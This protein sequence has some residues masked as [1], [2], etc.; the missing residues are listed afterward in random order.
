MYGSE[1][2]SEIGKFCQLCYDL[3]SEYQSKSNMGQQ[4]SSH[5]ASSVSN[6]F[7]LTYDEQD[8]LSKF[9]L[10]VHSTNEEAHAKLELDYYLEEPVL[11]RIS[12]FDV[13]SWWKTNGKPK[14]R[15]SL[16]F[17]QVTV[18]HPK[19]V[20]PTKTMQNPNHESSRGPAS[21]RKRVVAPPGKEEKVD[22]KFVYISPMPLDAP[23]CYSGAGLLKNKDMESKERGPCVGTKGFRHL[24]QELVQVSKGM[25]E[26]SG[27]SNNNEMGNGLS[28]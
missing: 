6:L 4:T 18:T 26:L 9:A 22:K 8:P 3:L 15:H 24:R 7:E 21:K 23:N 14:E 10:F 2:S 19:S 12:D 11:P 17:N 20:P 27:N 5:G 1:A 25:E 16:S 13:L 28:G